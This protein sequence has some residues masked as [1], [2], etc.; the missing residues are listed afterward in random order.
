MLETENNKLI[1]NGYIPKGQGEVKLTTKRQTPALMEGSETSAPKLTNDNGTTNCK[2]STVVYVNDE[3]HIG[4]TS[5]V[6]IHSNSVHENSGKWLL[7]KRFLKIK[8]IILAVASIIFGALLGALTVHYTNTD[9][10][11]YTTESK[12]KHN[13][14][15]L[16]EECVRSASHLLDA[17]DITVNPCED[18]FQYA[19]GT[20]NKKHVIPEDKSS[21]STF[22][23]LA[24][25]LQIIL[26]DILEEPTSGGDNQATI[27]AKTFYKSC[28]DIPQIRK[29]GEKRLKEILK[30]LG[31]WPVIETDWQLPKMTIEELLGELRSK[32]SESVLVELYVGADDKNSSAHI[33]QID[34]L[35]LALPSRDYYLKSSSEN[36]LKAYHKYMTK[37][38]V[39]LGAKP[40]IV[41]QELDQVLQFEIQLAN[42]TLPEADRHDTSA[43]YNKISLIAIQAQFPELNWT[44]FLQ[45]SLGPNINLQPDEELVVYAMS[46]L[47]KMCQLLNQ[48]DRRILHNYALWRL[49]MSVMAH[50]VDEYQQERFEFRRILLGIQSER[51][52]WGQCVEW[53][54][55]KLGMAVGALFIKNNFD[56]KSKEI[57]LEMIRTIR[58]AFN[59]LLAENH[60]MDDETRAVA[61]EK[62]DTMNERIG[63]PEILTNVNELEKEYL[64]LT[65]IPDNYMENILNILTWETEKNMELLRQPVD[66]AKWT[67]E[68]AVVNA[69]YNPN[70]NDI[71]FPAGI[72]QPLFYSQHYPKSLNYGGIGVVIGHEITH[73]FDDKGRQFDKD[74]NMMQWWNNA[75]I[76][77]FRGRT[78]CIIDQYSKYKVDEVGQYMNGRMTQGENIADNGGL[79]QAFR[80]YKKWVKQH[81]PELLLPGLNLTHDQLFFLNYAQIWCGSM[82][83]EDALTKIRSSVHSPGSIRVLG[84]LSN[85]KDFAE[86]YQCTPDSP[87]NPIEKCSVW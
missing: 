83:P 1:D 87:M 19:C 74:G 47:T 38:A 84:P 34:Q 17:M 25:N 46:Y 10:I 52:R 31:G 21:I 39:L 43:I 3:N 72:L 79:K 81:G 78:Q 32:Y 12:F 68:P 23:V 64:N 69:F 75:T 54:N 41:E 13:N 58:E 22:E 50:M 9:T 76:E 56:Q 35:S 27:K 29:F 80:A 6:R 20:W 36:A 2:Y 57:A 40:E 51:D 60:W 49:V 18:F 85:S 14:I 63:Y 77:A 65:I 59:E 70:K 26:K 37:T 5:S 7:K 28:M 45:E 86:A 82:R 66:K 62:A 55:K 30:S 61:K 16:T 8:Y 11:C 15:C 67:T 73:G 44:R 48:T 33:L 53:T 42:A 24:D 4:N 71:V